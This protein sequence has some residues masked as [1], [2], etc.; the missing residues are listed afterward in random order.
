V[1][2][3]PARGKPG[4]AV[5][6]VDEARLRML[7]AITPLGAES[8][9]IDVIG[10][11]RVLAEDVVAARSQPPFRS[12][13]MDGWAVRLDGADHAIVG[14][15][16]AGAPFAGVV[17]P[18]EA[19]RIFTG[20]PVPEG[21]D[22][23][24]VQEDAAVSGAKVRFAGA[25]KAGANI[26]ALGGD[27]LAGETLLAA[28]Q[29]LGAW[30]IALAAA[31]GKAAVSVA[32]SPRVALLACGDELAAPGGA[33]LDHQIYESITPA[34]AMRVRAWGGQP[35]RATV[36]DSQE[37]IAERL[38]ASDADLVVTIGGASVGDRDLMKAALTGLGAELLVNK[39]AMRPGKPVFFARLPEGGMVLGLP[40]N[41]ASALVCAELFLWPLMRALQGGEPERPVEAMPLAAPLG[42]T[43][44]REHWLR[45]RVAGGAVV[46]F[47]DQDSS[48]VS[49]LSQSNALI[50]R[51][52][53]A[54]ACHAG[55][56]VDVLRLEP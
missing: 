14:E 41:S 9:G 54:P 50:R 7:A 56:P 10:P 5:I 1:R 45:A 55:D 44:P 35:S 15:S 51:A 46:P 39:V 22:T 11:G 8:V 48:L 36:A 49:V 52:A 13:A 47:P 34:L 42:A 29:V 26:R 20:A 27:F 30:Q 2:T 40:G 43:G 6:R 53:G 23:V 38:A 24:V 21:A 31:A 28:G 19:V 25:P 37:A 17:G 16:A 32:R 12:S 33:A 18:G 4:D 3:I